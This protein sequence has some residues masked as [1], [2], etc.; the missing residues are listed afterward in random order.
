MVWMILP[1][2]LWGAPPGPVPGARLYQ[3]YCASCHGADGGGGGPVA[4]ALVMRPSDLR[5]LSVKNGGK[6]PVYRVVKMLGGAD[7]VRAHGGKQMPVWGPSFRETTPKDQQL[8]D[9]VKQLMAFLESI[10]EKPSK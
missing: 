10:Q 2:L 1:L 3:S 4:D 5:K 7:E 8:A 6:F 9:R